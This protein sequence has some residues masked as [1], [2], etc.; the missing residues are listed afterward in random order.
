MNKLLFCLTLVIHYVM[1]YKIQP[2]S[3]KERYGKGDVFVE[4]LSPALKYKQDF[5]KLKIKI[6]HGELY[7]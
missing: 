6:L 2:S 5:S 1:H 7:E 4:N 3:E